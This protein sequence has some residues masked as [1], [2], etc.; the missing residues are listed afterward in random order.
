MT[1]EL[2]EIHP[3]ELKFTFELKKQSSCLIQLTNKT[4]Q[5]VAFKVKT[6]S[7]KKYCVRPNTGIVKPK[8]ASDVTVTMQAQ[9]VAP[10]DLVCKDKFLIQSMVVPFGTAEEDI[11]SDMFSKESGKH[12][13]DKKLKVFFTS[14]SYSPVL[15]AINGESKQ[16]SAHETSSPRDK[17]RSGVENIPPPQKVAE[18]EL[19]FETAKAAVELRTTEDVQQ[20]ETSKVDKDEL[21]AADAVKSSPPK[22]VQELKPAKI[23]EQ[24]TLGHDFEELK[25][26]ISF[27]DSKLKEAE[28]SIMKLTE[29]RSIAVREKDKL[30]SEIEVLKRKSGIKTVQVGFPFLYVLMVALI[31]LGVGFYSHI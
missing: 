17:A 6:T 26:K 25:S 18:E 23:T 16:D 22:D 2:L 19:G 30:K 14:P 31:S 28:L 3:Q 5:Y 8:S 27:M 10:P 12:I 15:S 13:E 29:E 24:S 11:T 9:R 4:D 20:F 7:P 1:S 21:R